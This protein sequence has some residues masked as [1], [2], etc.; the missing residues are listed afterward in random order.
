MIIKGFNVRYVPMSM[1][2]YRTIEIGTVG[3]DDL[4][5][6]RVTFHDDPT[7][8]VYSNAFDA[9]TVS[10]L[11]SALFLAQQFAQ[12]GPD[13]QGYPGEQQEGGVQS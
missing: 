8:E 6:V 7:I 4:P 9:L 1:T 2:A 12:H 10:E 11:I 13:W 3:S 5:Y